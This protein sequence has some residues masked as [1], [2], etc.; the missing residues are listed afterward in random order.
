MKTN[1]FGNSRRHSF[2]LKAGSVLSFFL[3]SLF[4]GSVANGIFPGI[5]YAQPTSGSLTHYMAIPVV[6]QNPVIAAFNQEYPNIKVNLERNDT[7]ILYQKIT[8]EAR[9]GKIN[10]DVCDLADFLIMKDLMNKG[11]LAENTLPNDA[12]FPAPIKVKGYIYPY[13]LMFVNPV[14]NTKLVSQDDLPK[15]WMDFLNPKWKGKLCTTSPATGGSDWMFYYFLRK[16]FGLDYWKALAKQ[17]ITIYETSSTA[18]AQKIIAGE[19]QILIDATSAAGFT[20]KKKGEPID[21]YY[22]KEGVPL[23]MD[24]MGL[25][26]GGPNTEVGKVYL[27]FILSRKGQTA[28]S[29]ATGYYSALDGVPTPE[30]MTPKEKANIWYPDWEEWGKMRTDWINEWKEIFKR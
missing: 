17:D 1:N 18:V 23:S 27:N 26:K 10:G 7:Y 8:T 24:S 14:Y 16:K 4:F 21:M 25:L 29:M 9:A 5:G 20:L 11:V 15:S 30:G 6:Y 22:P 28:M 13:L 3:L 2:C 12:E 19:H